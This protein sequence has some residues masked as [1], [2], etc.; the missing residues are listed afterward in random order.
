MTDFIQLHT[1]T[2]YPPSC[3]NRD[4][5]GQPKSA[6]Y[7]G[8]PR[9][10]VS[11]QCQ[12]RSW[13]LSDTFASMTGDSNGSRTKL[14]FN[15]LAERI[16]GHGVDE[17][18]AK[19]YA[20]SI[21][22]PFNFV[23][24]KSMLPKNVLGFFSNGELEAMDALADTLAKEGRVATPEEITF[25]RV[26]TD[27]PDVALFGRMMAGNTDLNIEASISV[28]HSITTSAVTAEEDF[29]TAMDD[30]AKSS[31][32]DAAGFGSGVF[33]GY[34][35]INRDALIKNL[36]GD[37]VLADKTIQ[38]LITCATT[39]TPTGKQSTF[40]SPSYASYAMVERGSQQP[41]QL[42]TAFLK[43]IEGNNLLADSITSLESTLENTE[44]LYG[45]GANERSV[46][47]AQLGTGSL[48][49]LIETATSKVSE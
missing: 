45:K 23:D 8:A 46:M 16:Q 14:V 24:E 31:H 13:R 39:I 27:S 17:K 18:K 9:L 34:L 22:A 15:R 33:Y 47:N 48:Q 7:G 32:V 40:A 2:I 29:F 11:S 28:A 5:N 36:G 25:A 6:V 19:K 1:L 3:I 41:R 21:V 37:E 43:P 42:A 44:K 30:F 12:K 38:A 20:A 10:R 4:D 26:T 35:C 49:D